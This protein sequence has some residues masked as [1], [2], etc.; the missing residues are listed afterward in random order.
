[1]T[2]LCS[3]VARSLVTTLSQ[4]RQW[5]EK[6]VQQDLHLAAD[7]LQQSSLASNYSKI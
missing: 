1:M 4:V 7:F 5:P 6:I 3:C 2:E